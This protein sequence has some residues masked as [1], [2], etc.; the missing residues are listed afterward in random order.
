MPIFVGAGNCEL[1]I[2]SNNSTDVTSSAI[3]PGGVLHD[4][5]GV[6]VLLDRPRWRETAWEDIE[7]YCYLAA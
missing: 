2:S 6:V 7:R 1:A 3:M 4:E 5:A